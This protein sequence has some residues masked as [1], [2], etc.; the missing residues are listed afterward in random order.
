MNTSFPVLEH[1]LYKTFYLIF[2]LFIALTSSTYNPITTNQS[3]LLPNIRPHH[4]D[5]A[6]VIISFILRLVLMPNVTAYPSTFNINV[7]TPVL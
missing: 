5:V 4:L 3:S 7:C 1:R 6:A 2:S